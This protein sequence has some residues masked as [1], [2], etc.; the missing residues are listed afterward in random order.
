[1][2]RVVSIHQAGAGQPAL[3]GAQEYA[4]DGAQEARVVRADEEDQRR[5]QDAR[6]EMVSGLVGLHEAAQGL[7]V[8][9]VHDLL[10]ER[11]ADGEPEGAVRAGQ[12]ALVGQADAA[13]K[14][15]PEHD[16]GVDEVLLL[17]ANFPDGHVGIW[18]DVSRLAT[19]EN[20]IQRLTFV[21]RGHK[22]WKY[23]SR[24][25]VMRECEIP[26]IS[27][28]ATH[29]SHVTASLLVSNDTWDS[30]MRGLDM[31][32]LEIPSNAHYEQ[33]LKSIAAILRTSSLTITHRI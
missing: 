23:V 5:D 25:L 26:K 12:A 2:L 29:C 16:L 24:C 15:H 10:V 18:M 4:V 19:L 1:V 32:K 13:V 31:S 27:R 20:S 30:G 8:A 22:V 33:P 3:L 28:T 7:R 9:P 6:I 17:V 11:V 14:G 21:D